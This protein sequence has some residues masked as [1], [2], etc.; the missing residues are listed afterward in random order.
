MRRPGAFREPAVRRGR[1]WQT[2]CAASLK[3]TLSCGRRSFKILSQG[4][5]K[6]RCDCSSPTLCIRFGLTKAKPRRCTGLHAHF[7]EQ[8]TAKSLKMTARTATVPR[9]WPS[10]SLP[11]P[12]RAGPRT[13]NGPQSRPSPCR[14]RGR[15]AATRERSFRRRAAPPQRRR[16]SC[17]RPDAGAPWREARPG[18]RACAFLKLPAAHPAR[19]QL[20]SLCRPAP[21]RP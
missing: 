8:A 12:A 14:G 10:A 5:I 21:S 4:L 3:T 11:A 18:G 20:K 1:L 17:L 16:R 13:G 7:R 19:E 15:P 6:S 2:G 9:G